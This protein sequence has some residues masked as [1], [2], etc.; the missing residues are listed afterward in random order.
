LL[1]GELDTQWFPADQS[2]L[3]VFEHRIH[4]S[5]FDITPKSLFPTT[6]I[7]IGCWPTDAVS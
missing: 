2:R 5:R 4:V 7:F 1:S 3:V 6:S